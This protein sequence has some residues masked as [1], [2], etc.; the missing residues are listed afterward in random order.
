MAGAA[1]IPREIPLGIG[2]EPRHHELLDGSD[3]RR[4]LG[5]ALGAE[6]GEVQEH[7]PSVR[8]IVFAS[9][10][11][12]DE[13]GL[14]G[15]GHRL[16]PD[17]GSAGQGGTRQTRA[18]LEHGQGRVL[19]RS[20]PDAHADGIEMGP[21]SEL[22]LFD[23]VGEVRRLHGPPIVASQAYRTAGSERPCGW[24]TFQLN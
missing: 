14:E 11:S 23:D 20:Q 1:Q 9:D 6:R 22:E 2:I 15:G 12:V 8:R 18:L 16:G 10:E 19:R 3:A 7:A 21:Q 4:D 24:W 17:E 5:Q 13:E